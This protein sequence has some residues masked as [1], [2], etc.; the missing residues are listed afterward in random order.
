MIERSI[1]SKIGTC[2][3][4]VLA[5]LG[6]PAQAR[7]VGVVHVLFNC[8][9]ALLW[10]STTGGRAVAADDIEEPVYDI[11][12]RLGEVEIRRY[13]ASIQAVTSLSSNRRSGAGFQRLAG[14]ILTMLGNWSH[15]T[16]TTL[17]WL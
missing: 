12:Y 15:F 10:I 6:K 11:V 2:V 14:F 1:G 5:G 7:Q 13:D 4:A 16:E 8:L 3:T 17:S 9:G